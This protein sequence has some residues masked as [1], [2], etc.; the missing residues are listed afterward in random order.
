MFLRSVTFL[1]FLSL[2]S[3]DFVCLCLLALDYPDFW[4]MCSS[5][6]STC[7]K[8]LTPFGAFLLVPLSPSIWMW[9]TASPAHLKLILAFIPNSSKT[10]GE[11][12]ATSKQTL[13][14]LLHLPH[15]HSS[16]STDLSRH[17]RGQLPQL[18]VAPQ[19]AVSDIEP[20]PLVLYVVTAA[21]EDVCT[22]PRG[23]S[24][25]FTRSLFLS[26]MLAFLDALA[27]NV[28]HGVGES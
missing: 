8:P 2:N 3:N 28:S 14:S 13:P 22:L 7:I 5:L 23:S 19:F 16:F 20:D 26:L 9:I 4:H 17:W 10:V 24:F 25:S 12:N 6:F 27:W 1:T 21:V 11:K 18:G 15:I